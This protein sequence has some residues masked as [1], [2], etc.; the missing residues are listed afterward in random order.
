[1]PSR[2]VLQNGHVDGAAG[3]ACGAIGREAE[4]ASLHAHF[5]QADPARTFVLGGGPGIGKTTLWEA[6]IRAARERG[7][8]VLL[9]RPSDAEGQLAYAALIDLLDG[10]VSDELAELPS[11]QRRALDVAVLRAEPTGAP[12]EPSAVA[13]G[14]LNALRSLSARGPLLLAVDD[15]QWLDRPSAEA[16][17]FAAR[18]LEREPIGFL[19]A[20]RSGS[21]S[22]LEPALGRRRIEQLDVGPLSLG[23][24]RRLLSVRLGLALPSRLLRRL[25]ESA[26]GNPM[27]AIEL[28]RTLVG[29]ELPQIGEEIPFPDTLEELLGARVTALSAEARRALLAVALSPGL[30]A[31]QLES[32]AKPKGVDEALAAGVVAVERDRARPAHPLL[33]AAAVRHSLP[34]QRAAL[35]ARLARMTGD[36]VRQ[37]RHLA[38][39][40]AAPD[41]DAAGVIAAAAERA[42]ARGARH[43]AVELAEHALRLT[44]PERPERAGR[45]L[46]LGEYLAKAGEFE[47]ARSLLEPEMSA[48]PP[49]VERARAWLLLADTAGSSTPE[50]RLRYLER[51]LEESEGDPGLR[52]M[53]LAR[54]ASD[55]TAVQV[56]RLQDGEAWA[57]EALA[58]AH[59]AGDGEAQLALY[60]LAWARSFRGQ[61]IDDLLERASARDGI[62]HLR[63]SVERVAA[64]RFAW[65]GELG[66]ARATVRRLLALAEERGESRS[67]F[68][69]LSQLCEIELRAGDFDLTSQLLDQWEQSSSDRFAAPVYERCRLLVA[70]GRGVPEE[71]ERWAPDVIARSEMLESG[72]DLLEGLRARGIA[73]LFAR[74]P[75]RAVASLHRVWRYTVEEGIEDPGAFP[76]APDLV[77]ALVELGERDEARAV[78]RRLLERAEQQAHPWGL[79]TARRCSGLIRLAAPTYDEGAAA[80]V[81]DAAAGYGELG[82]RFER[83]RSLLGLGRAQR[84]LRRWKAARE[85][86]EQAAAAFGELGSPGWA[87]QAR[88]ELERVGARRP[89]LAGELTAAEQRVAALAADG[90]ANKEIARALSV[91]IHTVER[92]L[93][94]TYAKLG[95]RSRGQLARRLQERV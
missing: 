16:L 75:E 10:V 33:G 3:Y 82:L 94:H 30:R 32:L 25:F 45:V 31:P 50:E 22:S 51:T 39:A 58:E 68:A 52:A 12:P 1:M 6:G 74:E 40:S 42:D 70:V 34:R 41:P 36:T 92:H 93:S 4:L 8:R 53:V 23:A 84:R 21:A 26:G 55:A 66:E 44:P 91:S 79:V 86:L 87:E 88:S 81:A 72:W 89:A 69:L 71:I 38:L 18:R 78:A 80:E 90:L 17:T 19:L 35:H 85:S 63:R 73:D 24:T 64:D 43:E 2:A 20:K 48:L 7:L 76:V 13:V 46:A 29:R 57:R 11:P 56:A 61:P 9:A 49:G 77:E 95:V 67:Y 5:D 54:R 62:V 15:V 83:A 27:F 37:A 59:H 14:F 28:G 47:R 65:R 60:A